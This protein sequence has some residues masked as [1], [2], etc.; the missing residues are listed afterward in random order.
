M[1]SSSQ[2]TLPLAM[3]AYYEYPFEQKVSPSAERYGFSSVLVLVACC[4]IMLLL[5]Q[6]LVGRA[7]LAGALCW[8]SLQQE[9][10]AN[11]L[12]TE[13]LCSCSGWWCS[14]QLSVGNRV[15]KRVRVQTSRDR[16]AF[17]GRQAK[18]GKACGHSNQ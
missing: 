5:L 14:A 7:L 1:S 4:K 15:C 11:S 17:I 10:G 9:P 16:H 13:L 18:P 12:V 3:E 2:R 6:N 8:T